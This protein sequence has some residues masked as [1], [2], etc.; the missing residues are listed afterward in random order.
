MTNRNLGMRHGR[1]VEND[2]FDGDGNEDC[3]EPETWNIISALDRVLAKAEDSK[4]SDE[5][6]KTVESPVN[7]GCFYLIKP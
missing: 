6:W 1:R 3:K 7:Y 5:F 2:L 4:L